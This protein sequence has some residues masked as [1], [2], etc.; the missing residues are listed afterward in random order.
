MSNKEPKWIRVGS[1]R[2]GVD[3]ETGEIIP[4]RHY[5][6]VTNDV[7]LKKGDNLSLFPVNAERIQGLVNEGKLTE[8]VAEEI[9]ARTVYEV[10]LKV[11]K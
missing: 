4:G 7:S 2:K 8:D 11:K 1:I 5:L 6:S 3:R 10:S 9:I